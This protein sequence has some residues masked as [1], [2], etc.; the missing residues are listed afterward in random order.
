ML[1]LDEKPIRWNETVWVEWHSDDGF[2]LERYSEADEEL[3]NIPPEEVGDTD[4]E[5]A[6][7]DED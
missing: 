6:T 5:E 7:E 4:G 3:V 2:M 1:L